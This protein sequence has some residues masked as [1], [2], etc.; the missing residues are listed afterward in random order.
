MNAI[1]VVDRNWSIGRDGG[2][3]VHL[4]G[5]LA[6]FKKKTLGKTIIMGRKTLESL[7]GSKPLPGRQNIVLTENKEYKAPGCK[8]YHSKEQLMC[9]LSQDDQVFVAGGQSIYEQFMEDCHT[10]F[11]TKLDESYDADRKFPNLDKDPN[12]EMVAESKLHVENGTRYRFY[13]Y[14]RK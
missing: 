13:Q 3:L 14:K 5:E 10:F 6:Y 2:L 11:V 7:P 8:V 4:P 1:V 9:Q 12:I